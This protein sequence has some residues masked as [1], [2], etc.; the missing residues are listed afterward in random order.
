MNETPN[1]PETPP[2][3]PA[4][5][6]LNQ[7]EGDNRIPYSRFQQVNEEKKAL[8]DKVK[9]FE[10]AEAERQR[11]KAVEEGRFQDIIKDLEPKAKRVDELTQ[12]L[13]DALK[14]E[15]EAIPSDMHD[16]IP[17]GDITTQLVWIKKAR[18]AGVFNKPTPP[19]TN[20]GEPGDKPAPQREEPEGTRNVRDIAKQFGYIKPKG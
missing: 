12:A 2:S 17:E 6:P 1:N 4:T 14:E 9:A 3:N 18:K 8:Q 20:I 5:E 7:T 16:L 19:V 13:R 11:L 15:L 10:E